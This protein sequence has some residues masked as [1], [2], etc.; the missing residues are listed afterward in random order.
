MGS[1]PAGVIPM[2]FALRTTSPQGKKEGSEPTTQHQR[3]SRKAGTNKARQ[4]GTKSRSRLHSRSNKGQGTRD[5]GQGTRSRK[6][7]SRSK[8]TS[9]QR[10]GHPPHR[11]GAGSPSPHHKFAPKNQQKVAWGRFEKIFGKIFRGNVSGERKTPRVVSTEGGCLVNL[12]NHGKCRISNLAM[13]V[14]QK[15]TKALLNHRMQ[16]YGKGITFARVSA[17]NLL[18]VF[19]SIHRFSLWRYS[20]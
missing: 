4:Q 14:N 9:P 6:R 1:G 8:P 11:Q 10:K 13:Q 19:G 15:R 17:K 16:R 12:T 2:L 20:S 3:Q 7:K 5:K 18:R